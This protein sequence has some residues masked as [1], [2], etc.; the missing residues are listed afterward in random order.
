MW[1]GVTYRL[2]V[3]LW[4]RILLLL[5]LLIIKMLQILGNIVRGVPGDLCPSLSPYIAVRFAAAAAAAA[6]R[7]YRA[8]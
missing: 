3:V 5:L 2:L 4:R 6:R 8:P 1:L 7:R